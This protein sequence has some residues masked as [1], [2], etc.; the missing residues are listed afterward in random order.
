[1]LSHLWP[2][3]MDTVSFSYCALCS[4]DLL[5]RG[6]SCVIP[7]LGKSFWSRD[8]SCD[9]IA[10]ELLLVLESTMQGSILKGQ[11]E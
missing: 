8:V 10:S 5:D 11:P 7:V 3:K 9:C 1:M 4:F 6:L 2:N